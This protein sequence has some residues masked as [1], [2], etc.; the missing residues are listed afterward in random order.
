MN[1]RPNLV[2]RAAALSAATLHEAAGRIGAL[3]ARIQ[4][5]WPGA[6]LV[7]PAF[8]L[9]VSAGTNLWLHRAV[10]AAAPGD[11]LICAVGAGEEFGYWGEILAV[12]AQAR[13][14]AGLVIDGCVRDIDQIRELAF[15]IFSAGRSIRGTGKQAEVPGQ[16]GAPIEI[17]GVAIG[18][19]D[20]V[21]GDSD[22]LVVIPSSL[23]ADAV[24]GGEQ[25]DAKEAGMLAELRAGATTI[26]L[27]GLADR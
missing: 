13:G 27:L 22:G 5:A 23:A 6:R 16:M 11:V 17:G 12:A 8:P 10:Y 18:R 20:L 7:G 14:L 26:D 3:P 15:P 21:V 1:S 19:G 9:F 4:A 2:D 24:A 25:R